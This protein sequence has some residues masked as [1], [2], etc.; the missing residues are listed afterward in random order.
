MF[1]AIPF[2]ERVEIG[3]RLFECRTW[4]Q[5]GDVNEKARA[6]A[7]LH[8]GHDIRAEDAGDVNLWFGIRIVQ[9]EAGRQNTDDRCLEPFDAYRFA[10]DVRISTEPASPERV[11][12][13]R[14]GRGAFDVVFGCET[15]TERR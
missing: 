11:G 7:D 10:D 3:L 13:H 4:L 1:L 6:A 9:P 5:S 12:G 8:G 2:V 15:S 14:N